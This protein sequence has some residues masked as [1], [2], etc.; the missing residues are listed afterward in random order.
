MGVKADTT[1]P[2]LFALVLAVLLGYRWVRSRMD[3]TPKS[4]TLGIETPPR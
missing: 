1:I 3:A 4:A 2:I